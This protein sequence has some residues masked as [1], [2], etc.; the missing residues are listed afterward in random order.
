MC[1]YVFEPVP[2][3][4][5]NILPYSK[6]GS[7]RRPSEAYFPATHAHRIYILIVAVNPMVQSL[8]IMYKLRI[9][10]QSDKVII[11]L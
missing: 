2:A 10:F 8:C 4:C 7:D 1:N 5:E 9:K 6:R 3:L 11:D